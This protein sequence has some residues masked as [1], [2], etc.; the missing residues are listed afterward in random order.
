M[1][2]RS[3]R[4]FTRNA[5]RYSISCDTVACEQLIKR[6][7]SL[8]ELSLLVDAILSNEDGSRAIRSLPVDD[9]QRLVD[10]IDEVRSGISHCNDDQLKLTLPR[11]WIRRIFCPWLKRS[12]SGC[13]TERAV[14][15]RFSRGHSRFRSTSIKPETRRT[16]EVMRMCGKGCITTGTLRSRSS[17]RIQIACCRK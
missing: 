12:A 8:H 1:R 13:C 17:G 6:N 10:A 5:D 14:T 9:A 16:G 15:M 2:L 11:R 7:F 4:L 3:R